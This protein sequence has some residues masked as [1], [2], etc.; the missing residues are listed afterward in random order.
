MEWILTFAYLFLKS[1]MISSINI[2]GDEAPAVIPIFFFPF[3]QSLSISSF[4]E[5]LNTGTFFF[6]TISANLLVFD[7]FS[8]P[9][10]KTM[11]DKSASLLT[12]VCLF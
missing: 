10:T 9:T 8:P 3:S 6:S 1:S 4:P 11:S 5:T 2:S 7:E 12:A